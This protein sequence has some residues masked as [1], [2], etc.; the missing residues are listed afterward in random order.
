VSFLGSNSCVHFPHA[1]LSTPCIHLLSCI[2]AGQN[3]RHALRHNGPAVPVKPLHQTYG[4]TRLIIRGRA[5]DFEGNV[6]TC[7]WCESRLFLDEMPGS[8]Q[9]LCCANGKCVPVTPE[10]VPEE[11]LAIFQHP[12]WPRESKNINDCCNFTSTAVCRSL[13]D[14]GRGLHFS[15]APPCVLKLEGSIVHFA[16][17]LC[18]TP[19]PQR[20][21]ASAIA[22]ASHGWFLTGPRSPD[23]LRPATTLLATK[24]RSL[25]LK[26]HPCTT[27]SPLRT[28]QEEL[29]VDF[30]KPPATDEVVALYQSPDQTTPPQVLFFDCRKQDS[31]SHPLQPGELD[32][33]AFPLLWPYATIPYS[34]QSPYT[35]LKWIRALLFRQL[36]RFT[37]ST[38]LFQ[39]YILTLWNEI[40][41]SRI[42]YI[43]N[44]HRR[45]IGQFGSQADAQDRQVGSLPAQFQGGPAFY[46]EHVGA[47]LFTAS[48]KGFHNVLFTTMTQPPKCPVAT[49]IASTS[50]RPT[51]VDNPIM[52]VLVRAFLCAR[53]NLHSVMK[54]GLCLPVHLTCNALWYLEAVEFQGRGLPHVHRLDC[55][56]GEPW[57]MANIDGIVW[58]HWPSDEEESFFFTLYDL[59]LRA[60]VDKHMRHR[61]TAYCGGIDGGKCRC[62]SLSSK[63]SCL[64][65]YCK[66]QML[67]SLN[68]GS[69]AAQICVHIL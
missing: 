27:Y 45:K 50:Q 65:P 36:P 31:A 62:A 25:L 6:C 34:Q 37:L 22:Q 13:T 32:V 39:S 1:L 51:Q 26:T 42:Q 8:R 61:H 9:T 59:S 57:S 33:L 67:Q 20:T 10:E 14:G 23:N 40:E 54:K 35:R 16:Q 38:T 28:P 48:K 47:T 68:F 18:G 52:D 44:Q 43:K 17:N 69:L 7:P 64:C 11:L 60:L 4:H 49:D 41:T 63:S 53:D 58:A 3:L 21:T 15:T 5:F 2:A 56:A 24:A 19:A 46:T 66:L 12:Q 55:Y 30:E 29:R